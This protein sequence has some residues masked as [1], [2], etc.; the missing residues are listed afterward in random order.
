[1]PDLSK[2]DALLQCPSD[3]KV[4]RFNIFRSIISL[5]KITYQKWLNNPF[6]Q[7]NQTRKAIGVEVGGD[8]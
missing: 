1:M 5:N 3:T 8:L 6:S 7:R 2:L 4:S